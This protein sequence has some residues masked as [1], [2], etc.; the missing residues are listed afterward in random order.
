MSG[1]EGSGPARRL[2][3]QAFIVLGLSLPLLGSCSDLGSHF[4]RLSSDEA[5]VENVPARG[6]PIAFVDR[7]VAMDIELPPGNRGI[8]RNQYVDVYRFAAKYR[9]EGT[10]PL[11]LAPP[12]SRHAGG[13]RSQAVAEIRQALREGGVDPERIL[14]GKPMPGALVSL[15]YQKPVAVA[16]QCGNWPR[17]VGREPERVAHPDFGCST[18]R[19]LAGMVA[20]SRDFMQSQTETPASGERRARVWSQYTTGDAAASKGTASPESATDAKAKG[21]KK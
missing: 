2:R 6:H 13:M 7:D 9:E 21:T 19:N 4:H 10:G 8:S 17:D 18:Q 5:L 15:A 14:A 20:N 16:P 3:L 12:S 1:A 11:I